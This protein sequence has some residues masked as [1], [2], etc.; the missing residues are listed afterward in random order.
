MYSGPSGPEE[1]NSFVASTMPRFAE[2][3]GVRRPKKSNKS[4][5]PTEF[6][7]DAGELGQG[8]GE[9]KERVEEKAKTRY[10]H[11]Y[12]ALLLW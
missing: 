10:E 2:T 8:E 3:P 12:F 5:A 4:T 1:S 7:Y 9:G 6:C 11:D